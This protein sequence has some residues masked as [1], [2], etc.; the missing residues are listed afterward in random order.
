MEANGRR[1]S[2]EKE[3]TDGV[4]CYQRVEGGEDRAKPVCF[5]LGYMGDLGVIS[6]EE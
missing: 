1:C 6:V 4:K 3:G 2:K 5:L